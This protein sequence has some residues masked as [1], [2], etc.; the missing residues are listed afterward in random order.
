MTDEELIAE[1]QRKHCPTCKRNAARCSSLFGSGVSVENRVCMQ[2]HKWTWL[3]K[4]VTGE[5]ELVNGKPKE[6]LP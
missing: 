6:P 3:K 5:W 1:L 4:T 2:G